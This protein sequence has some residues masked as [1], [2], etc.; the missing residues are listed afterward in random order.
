MELQ[1][2]GWDNRCLIQRSE[3]LKIKKLKKRVTELLLVAVTKQKEQFICF[4]QGC[5]LEDVTVTNYSSVVHLMDHKGIKEVSQYHCW[6]YLWIVTLYAAWCFMLCTW[7]WAFFHCCCFVHSPAFSQSLHSLRFH[8]KNVKN[9]LTLPPTI[10]IWPARKFWGVWASW[11][12]GYM[13]VKNQ[14]LAWEV[15]FEIKPSAS[16]Y[17]S[18]SSCGKYQLYVHHTSLYHP[19]IVL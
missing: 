1:K 8:E 6:V 7:I 17:S 3:T 12:I 9:L 18:Y 5:I 2:Q 15:I 14:N 16:S 11:P 4:V 13:V 19:S 10:S